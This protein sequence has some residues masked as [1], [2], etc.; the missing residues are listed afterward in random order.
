[1]Q[2]KNPIKVSPLEPPP[3]PKFLQNLKAEVTAQWPMTSLLDM[4]KEA[5]F[6]IGFTDEFRGL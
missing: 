5:D 6:Q 2:G 1:M 3:E 4:V